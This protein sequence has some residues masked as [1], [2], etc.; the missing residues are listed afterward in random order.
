ML[1]VVVVVDCVAATGWDVCLDVSWV[2]VS[3]DFG[4]VVVGWD[5]ASVDIAIVDIDI[6][7]VVAIAVVFYNNIFQ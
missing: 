5:V 7:V 1:T 4:W 3:S 6:V 2:G